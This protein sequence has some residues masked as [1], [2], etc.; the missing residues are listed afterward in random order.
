MRD[1]ATRRNNELSCGSSHI[2]TQIQIT[3]TRTTHICAL[4]MAR[5]LLVICTIRVFAWACAWEQSSSHSLECICQQMWQTLRKGT[6]SGQCKH[7]GTRQNS[8]GT[9]NSRNRRLLHHW[10]VLCIPYLPAKFET[11]MAFLR[12][13][14]GQNSF[15]ASV[16]LAVYGVDQKW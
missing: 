2:V 11:C 3:L 12:L 6:T 10:K 4:Q 7:M 14:Q 1:S 5:A 9:A 8:R 15:T 16:A 13:K